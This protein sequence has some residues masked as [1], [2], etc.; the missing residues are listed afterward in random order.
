MK[1]KFNGSAADL[2]FG[3]LGWSV[4]MLLTAGLAFPFALKSFGKY[5][6]NNCEIIEEKK[7]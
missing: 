4:L 6:A 1:I 7:L 2:F 5:I 3:W